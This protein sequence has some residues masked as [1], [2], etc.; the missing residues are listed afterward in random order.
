MATS[1]LALPDSSTVPATDATNASPHHQPPLALGR[2]VGAP[3]YESRPEK[4]A[5]DVV[6]LLQSTNQDAVLPERQ[7]ES[8]HF[9]KTVNPD[10]KLGQTANDSGE[11]LKEYLVK[12]DRYEH[13]VFDSKL[14]ISGI[15]PRYE[16]ERWAVM[17]TSYPAPCSSEVLL[18]LFLGNS[19]NLAPFSYTQVIDHDPPLFIIGFAGGFSHAKDTLTNLAD[20]KV[21]TVRS[22]FSRPIFPPPDD[23]LECA[24]MTQS[25]IAKVL[26]GPTGHFPVEAEIVGYLANTWSVPTLLVAFAAGWA[27]ILGATN[28]G[29][30]RH[31][32]ALGAGDR[33]AILWFVLSTLKP[34]KAS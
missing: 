29:V 13:V 16:I 32:P 20:T 25:P 19:T 8:W 15:I 3:S 31:N 4:G 10:W 18:K 7:E 30:R 6:A 17:T 28:I 11:C 33:A 5:T 1:R 14:L 24:V 12:I 22:I 26:G 2:F 9:T 23:L 21:C 34:L 27:V